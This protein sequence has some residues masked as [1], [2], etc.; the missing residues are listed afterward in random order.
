M[1]GIQI[2]VMRFVLL[3]LV[4]QFISPIFLSV[5]TP[6]ASTVEN[7]HPK[8]HAHH[9]SIVAPQLLKEKDETETKISEVAVEFVALIDFKDHSSVLEEFHTNKFTP[10]IFRERIDHRPPL[11]TL[12]RVFLI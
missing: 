2:K 4:V 3:L 12:H 7:N 9:C 10:F 5:I 6:G 1:P 11:F 8:L